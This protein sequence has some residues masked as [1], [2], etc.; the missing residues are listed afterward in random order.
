[1]LEVTMKPLQNQVLSP[2]L[3]QYFKVLQ[4]SSEELREYMEQMA[5]DNPVM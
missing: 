2:D 5:Q 3:L 4:F 1:M